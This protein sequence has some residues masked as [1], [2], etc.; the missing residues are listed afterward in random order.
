M[1][2]PVLKQDGRIVAMKGRNAA[3]EVAA[4]EGALAEMGAKVEAVENF[5]LP[6]S[7]DA[8]SLVIIVKKN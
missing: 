3:E 5:V 7:G 1:A 2:L 8:R 4:A 6:G